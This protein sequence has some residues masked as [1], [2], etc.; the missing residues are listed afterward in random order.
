MYDDSHNNLDE[1][2]E[3]EANKE[4]EAKRHAEAI[5]A[6][7]F[8]AVHQYNSKDVDAIN[9]RAKNQ[10]NNTNKKTNEEKSTSSLDEKNDE[11]K[12]SDDKDKNNEN[13]DKKE[14]PNNNKKFNASDLLNSVN[15]IAKLKAKLMTIKA[16]LML[17]GIIA[18]IFGIVLL[19]VLFL[20][21]FD[22]L[23][24]SISSFFGI[25]EDTNDENALT[26]N[27]KYLY[28]EDGNPYSKDELVEM[29][30]KDNECSI[31][32]F[33]TISD[34]FSTINGKFGTGNFC[35][36]SRYVSKSI[37][38]LEE[39]NPGLKMDRSLLLSG[40][41]YGY[42]S[43]PNNLEYINPSSI[44]DSV[45]AVDHYKS[46]I[47]MLQDGLLTKADVDEMINAAV[48][49]H[50]HNYY[51]WKIVDEYDRNGNIVRSTGYCEEHETSDVKYSLLRW[52]M[53]MRYGKD[54]VDT[55]DFLMKRKKSYLESSEECNGTISDS[56]LMQKLAQSGGVAVLDDSV[57]KAKEFLSEYGIPQNLELFEQKAT[58]EGYTKDVLQPY[59]YKDKSANFDYRTG[60]VYKEFPYFEQAYN[61]GQ[62]TLEY[63]DAI[64]PKIIET[65]ITQVVEKKTY[66]NE[67]LNLEDQDNPAYFQQL[68]QIWSSVKGAYCSEYVPLPFNEIQ[69]VVEDCDG[70]ELGTTN[71]K[72]Y[73]MG[74]A[75]GEVSNSGDDYVKSEMVAA[76]SYALARRNNYSKLSASQN[77]IVMK[78]GNCDQVYCSMALGCS[79]IKSNLDCGG[80]KCTSYH[81]GLNYTFYHGAAG[82]A[83]I[84]KYS[85]LYDEA[86]QF[87]LVK[88]GSVFSAGYVSTVQNKWKELSDSGMSFTQIM[89]QT[90]GPDG[91]ELVRCENLDEEGNLTSDV[92]ETTNNSD[93]EVYGQ[94]SYNNE[95]VTIKKVGNTTNDIYNKKAPDLGKFY[96]YSYN[97]EPAGRNITIN[98]K[99]VNA[100]IV[101]VDSD[102]GNSYRV[103]VQAKN[104][105]EM[106]FKNISNILTNGV[107]LSDG[108]VCKYKLD[109]L[110]GGNTFEQR[111]TTSGYFSD[112][113]YGITQ[114]WNY[115]KSYTINGKIYMPYSKN[116]TITD[117]NDF[118]N[119]LGKEEDCRNV[120]YILYK[121]AYSPAGFSWSRY[122]E[123][124]D[125]STFTINY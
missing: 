41:F 43:Q 124:Y 101:N 53:F 123:I 80:F 64:T 44:P 98:P 82:D 103:N 92:N 65:L 58:T 38:K 100:N 113:S 21:I 32:I 78:S 26:I 108:S 67:I 122:E 40:M 20:I 59:S 23:M 3:I 102:W 93:A 120:N 94:G 6:S 60:Y 81:P 109:D 29:L 17:I 50:T 25:V 5:L 15:P 54:V 22:V 105:Y 119:A 79:S 68:G 112:E 117:Y 1:N 47:D 116:S 45:E 34:F 18:H 110:Q 14:E 104:N 4:L 56:V 16:S 61:S 27:D 66:M 106:A 11:L 8:D 84:Q 51:Q 36:Y 95:N 72:D 86:S 70:R 111:K 69:V 13:Q 57:G 97:D 107:V 33:S 24:N 115:N 75:Y 63:D 77:K 83:L 42:A 73:I 28:D 48:A 39:E 31:T 30:K 96:G 52:Q 85:Q 9:K 19:I 55:Y 118:V 49:D 62:T 74:V 87:L 76:I 35:A 121:Y 10:I 99:W 90:Y 2:G 71:F 37:D 88:D 125:G 7:G 89:Q 91:A 12:S 114:S 46:L